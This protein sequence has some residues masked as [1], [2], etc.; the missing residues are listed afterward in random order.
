LKLGRTAWRK[1]RNFSK[2]VQAFPLVLLLLMGW[3]F[4]EL[5]GYLTRR[6]A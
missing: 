5:L 1:R 2:F 3:G 6:P 4:G